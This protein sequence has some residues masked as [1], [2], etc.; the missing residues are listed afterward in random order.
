VKQRWMCKNCF[1]DLLFSKTPTFPIYLQKNENSKNLNYFK[2]HRDSAAIN[3]FYISIFQFTTKNF[4]FFPIPMRSVL[5][6][7]F[8]SCSV[9]SSLIQSCLVLFSLLVHS[10]T[11]IQNHFWEIM[12]CSRDYKLDICNV[13][14]SMVAFDFKTTVKH[15]IWLPH[16]W[17]T[18][19][20]DG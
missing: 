7:L 13:F 12:Y 11:Y 16:K 20:N 6:N 4:W 5:F 14:W 10:K 19:L 2:V 3:H 1:F 15:C 17:P 9:L 8:Q 18:L